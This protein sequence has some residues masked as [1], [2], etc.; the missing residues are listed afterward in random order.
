MAADTQTTKTFCL[1]C[2]AKLVWSYLFCLHAPK[3]FNHFD[4]GRHIAA[5]DR[6]MAEFTPEQGGAGWQ[7]KETR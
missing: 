3:D 6:P 5:K 4:C 2:G 7:A 1:Y